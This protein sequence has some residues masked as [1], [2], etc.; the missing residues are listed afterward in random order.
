METACLFKYEDSNF[1]VNYNDKDIKLSL[2]IDRILDIIAAYKRLRNDMMKDGD[3]FPK[4]EGLPLILSK[5]LINPEKGFDSST[6]YKKQLETMYNL[7][8]MAPRGKEVIHYNVLKTSTTGEIS[9]EYAS[10]AEIVVYESGTGPNKLCINHNNEKFKNIGSSAALLDPASKVDPSHFFPDESITAITFDKTFTEKLGFPYN[11]E[12]STTMEKENLG[13]FNV[14]IKFD[15]HFTTKKFSETTKVTW[16]DPIAIKSDT[17]RE[18]VVGNKEKNT[19]INKLWK[20]IKTKRTFNEKDNEI[21]SK[22]YKLLL[23]K[24]LGDVAQ[25]WM[26]F[27]LIITHLLKFN[28]DE[29]KQDKPFPDMN[30]KDIQ[31]IINLFLMITTDSVVYFLCKTF[32]I[33]AVYTGSREGVTSGRCTLKYFNV[34]DPDYTLNLKNLIERD[35]NRIKQHNTTTI[36]CL[37]QILAVTN[38]RTGTGLISLKLFNFQVQI[39]FEEHLIDDP[40]SRRGPRN[41]KPPARFGMIDSD[42]PKI[43]VR[44]AAPIGNNVILNGND[45]FSNQ[46]PKRKQEISDE[47]KRRFEELK[48]TITSANEALD[49]TFDKLSIELEEQLIES[50]TELNDN[51]NKIYD[52]LKKHKCKQYI[53]ILPLLARV[54]GVK[55]IFNY[56]ELLRIDDEMTFYRPGALQSTILSGTAVKFLK[57]MIPTDFYTLQEKNNVY[58]EDKLLDDDTLMEDELQEADKYDIETSEVLKPTAIKGGGKEYIGTS[59][60][61]GYYESL[62][63]YYIY[64]F[65]FNEKYIECPSNI[66]DDILLKNPLNVCLFAKYY[67]MFVWQCESND[68]N[69]ELEEKKVGHFNKIFEKN[70]D[71]EIEMFGA[72]LSNYIHFF[73]ANDPSIQQKDIVSSLSQ[74]TQLK[75]D[76]PTLLKTPLSPSKDAGPIYP[77]GLTPVVPK[78]VAPVVPIVP[79][80]PIDSVGPVDLLARGSMIDKQKA[81]R[82]TKRTKRTKK[83]KRN[84]RNKRTKRNKRNKRNIRNKRTKKHKY[85]NR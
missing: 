28:Y 72:K 79:I 10:Q 44:I 21:L 54:R 56:T 41:V 25:V 38:T 74:T 51:Y 1:I 15:D 22:I 2:T 50:E 84:K 71:R 17:I 52:E 43:G 78:P 70:T 76:V 59:S 66:E 67:D 11:L 5:V 53:T 23:M 26:Y 39:N 8:T 62:I 61:I 85:Y 48:K 47:L 9:D 65:F 16:H 30:N 18:L 49:A 75:Y 6:D 40:T 14:T 64:T 73:N 33:P 57:T 12:W 45:I 69:I 19:E 42:R 80:V 63:M 4:I 3:E 20:L 68:W 31:K 35:K 37:E 77:V 34:G 29:S 7:E 60:S 55:F 82:R 46:K 27:A 81:V 58:G 36:K 13:S 24:E 83:H 32:I